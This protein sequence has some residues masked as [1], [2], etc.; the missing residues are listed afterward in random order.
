MASFMQLIP[1]YLLWKKTA[2]LFSI[3]E[4]VICFSFDQTQ[5]SHMTGAL[6]THAVYLLLSI[7]TRQAEIAFSSEAS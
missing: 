2:L 5:A 4:N 1:K 6:L 3:N 7:P